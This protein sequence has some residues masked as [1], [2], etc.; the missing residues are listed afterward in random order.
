MTQ[1]WL[2]ILVQIVLIVVV[3]AGAVGLTNVWVEGRPE[4]E[5]HAPEP[6]QPVVS[7]GRIRTGDV[8]LHVATQGTVQAAREGVLTAELSGAIVWVAPELKVGNL[9]DDGQ[10]LLRIDDSSY[11]RAVA[12]AESQLAQ[13][14]LLLAQERAQAARA[15]REWQALGEGE[16][17]PLTLR[18]PQVQSAE[19]ALAAAEVGLT[20]A[21][22]EL[23]RTEVRAPWPAQVVSEQAAVGQWVSPG[24]ELARL[25]GLDAVEVHIPLSL[26]QTRELGLRPGSR[27][28][29]VTPA[30]TCHGEALGE[31]QWRGRLL[32]TSARLDVRNRMLTAIA[33]LEGD[34]LPPVGAFLDVLI[35]GQEHQG[36]RRIPAAALRGDDSVWLFEPESEGHGRIRAFPVEVLRRHSDEIIGRADIPDGAPVVTTRIPGGTEGMLVRVRQEKP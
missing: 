29:A 17:D 8:R 28:L 9:I 3:L 30:V 23:Q 6:Y 4:P 34:D 2:R 25:Q 33:L 1:N 12:Q 21:R 31:R 35:E 18:Q 26:A 10:V 14:R 27:E 5:R 16:A 19:A 13:Q 7:L 36:L 32:R 11:R 24:M 20:R 22:L 15:Q